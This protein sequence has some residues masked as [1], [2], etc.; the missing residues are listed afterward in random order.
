MTKLKIKFIWLFLIILSL[1]SDKFENTNGT[2]LNRYGKNDNDEQD[3]E[4]IIEDIL[5][6]DKN[7]EN[8]QEKNSANEEPQT[9]STTIT[10]PTTT[11]TSTIKTTISS[12]K[13][14]LDEHQKAESENESSNSWTMFFI[15]C[16]LG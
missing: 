1:L 2:R 16:V 3:L 11:T 8:L 4:K 12:T 14:V 13:N 10:T 9:T 7:E 6:K 15:L 5:S